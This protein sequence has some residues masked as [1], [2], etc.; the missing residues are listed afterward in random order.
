MTQV[1]ESHR[2]QLGRLMAESS[3]YKADESTDL[4]ISDAEGAEMQQAAADQR[5]AL[6]KRPGESMIDWKRRTQS[7]AS[8][9][10]WNRN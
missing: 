8:A 2:T 9:K 5:D 6:S 10:F 1:V 3:H 4:G 7:P